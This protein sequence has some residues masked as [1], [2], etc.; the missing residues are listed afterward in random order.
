MQNSIL[1]AVPAALT[2]LMADLATDTGVIV[3][4]ALLVVGVI[5]GIKFLIGAFRSLVGRG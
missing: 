5:F 3:T 2:D 1:A 4:A